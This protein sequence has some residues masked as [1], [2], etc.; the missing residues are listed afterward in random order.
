MKTIFFGTHEFAATILTG[1]LTDPFFEV[2]L[3]ITQP[4]RPV[5]RH[6]NMQKSPVA[7]VAE[8][9]NIPLVQPET[10]KEFQL[11]FCEIAIV[12][13]YGLLIPG[14]ILNGPQF[15][16][17]NV[18]P[19]LL[20]TYRGPTPIQTALI[21]GDEITGTT[22]M[23][24]DAGMDTG[25]ILAQATYPIRP[26]DTFVQ[27]SA[28]LANLSVPLLIKAI[29]DYTQGQLTPISQDDNGASICKLLT[30]EDG[31]INW[32][33]NAEEIYHQFQGLTPWPGIWCV[34]QGKRLK[35]LKITTDPSEIS[36]GTVSVSHD[37]LLIG[38]NKGSLHVGTLQLEGKKAMD[39]ITFLKGFRQF[40]GSRVE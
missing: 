19:S 20:P 40:D 31:K 15:G 3:I 2:I 38:T 28:N 11:P 1:I 10:L 24:L 25:P 8:K 37:R 17:I 39:A 29:K 36:P 32:L 34:W 13:Q 12:A 14:R 22:I 35:L 4:D 27:L 23:K 9:N 6:Q 26:N 18:H 21:N 7:L 30:R 5:G 16:I 33:K